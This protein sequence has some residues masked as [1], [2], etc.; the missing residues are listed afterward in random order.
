MHD[1]RGGFAT[2]G[3]CLWP[4]PNRVQRNRDQ[5]KPEHIGDK[6]TRLQ[7]V[8]ERDPEPDY[9]P[10]E[11]KPADEPNEPT[12]PETS[13]RRI[14]RNDAEPLV[15]RRQQ[16]ATDDI[17]DPNDEKSNEQAKQPLAQQRRPIERKKGADAAER[18]RHYQTDRKRKAQRDEM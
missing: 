4:A 5:N 17:R 3:E 6:L 16:E 7:S 1:R 13:G 9:H 12:P 2:P 14:H 15:I 11:G 18:K 10:T 8:A